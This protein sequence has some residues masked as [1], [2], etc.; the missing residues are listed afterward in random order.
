MTI[1]R[2]EYGVED[3]E[4][5]RRRLRQG[6]LWSLCLH[7]L[8]IGAGLT[9]PA[10][11]PQPTDQV[12][13]LAATLQLPPQR[14]PRT[15]SQLQTQSGSRSAAPLIPL[16]PA[17]PSSVSSAVLPAPTLE[18]EIDVTGSAARPASSV[19]AVKP[20]AVKSSAG[21]LDADALRSY[22]IALAAQARQF[23]RYPPQALTAGWEGTVD[24]RLSLPATGKP[25]AD[26]ARSTG[27]EVLDR[28]ALDMVETAAGRVLIPSPLQGREFSISL[29]VTFSLS[30][31]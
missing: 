12:A 16:P 8:L 18:T 6:L 5:R 11:T 7:G 24:V 22:R 1:Q 4:D 29:P 2:Q 19:S 10:L 9:L 27:Y 26:L 20:S 17:L 14:P 15:P 3:R 25:T 23:K 30:D 28:A 21:K 13:Y 31:P